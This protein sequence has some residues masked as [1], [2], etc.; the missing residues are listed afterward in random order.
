MMIGAVIA[1][2]V[3]LAGSLVLQARIGRQDQPALLL[4]AANQDLKLINENILVNLALS[5]DDRGSLNRQLGR[6][7]D[8]S[9]NYRK[10]SEIWRMLALQHP[11]VREYR[12]R[13]AGTEERLRALMNRGATEK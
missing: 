2:M 6:H 12:A 8:A 7:T 11:G 1:T 5:E 9:D 4:K 13:L 3:T 10:A